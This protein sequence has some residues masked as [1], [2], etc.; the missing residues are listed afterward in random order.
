MSGLPPQPPAKTPISGRRSP[1]SDI[2]EGDPGTTVMPI[3]GRLQ[4]T[5]DEQP[6]LVDEDV[7]DVTTDSGGPSRVGQAG[8]LPSTSQPGGS[9]SSAPGP[10]AVGRTSTAMAAAPTVVAI[11]HVL[12]C[13][14]ISRDTEVVLE[15]HESDDDVML[16][17]ALFNACAAAGMAADADE[18]ALHAIYREFEAQRASM[19]PRMA[20]C[21]SIL[22]NTGANNLP[23]DEW[24]AV[25]DATMAA[26]E[27]AFVPPSTAVVDAAVAAA[28][29]ADDHETVALVDAVSV[30]DAWP[31]AQTDDAVMAAQVTA[32][33]DGRYCLGPGGEVESRLPGAGGHPDGGPSADHIHVYGARWEYLTAT[34]YGICERQER[35]MKLW[36]T[37][38][39]EPDAPPSQE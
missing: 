30:I 22:F 9:T 3:N 18:A 8:A 13:P 7:D 21:E 33:V 34:F 14:S 23:L 25:W 6:R 35:R 26:L 28:D 24:E 32:M 1:P 4:R 15:G 39:P 17:T 38:F 10:L 19:H 29:N 20:A 11:P 31:D 37:A 16:T 27:P 36:L 5:S 12:P 2:E